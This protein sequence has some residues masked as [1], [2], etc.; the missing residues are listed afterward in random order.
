MTK[1][2]TDFVGTVIKSICKQ[3]K[4]LLE[5]KKKERNPLPRELR[6]RKGDIPATS[7]RIELEVI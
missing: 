5:E 2:V 4:T 6:R 1:Y 3:L 7:T